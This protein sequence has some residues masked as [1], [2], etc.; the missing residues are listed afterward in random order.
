MERTLPP[1]AAR[2][3]YDLIGRAYDLAGAFE[4]R[5]QRLG[6]QQL[7]LAPGLRTL[8]IGVGTGR[9]HRHL[10]HAVEPGGLA[11]GVDLSF[12]MA[13]LTRRRTGSPVCQASA[14]RLP[15][16]DQSFDR[17][18]A[19]Y[20]LDLM[21]SADLPQA[22]DEFRR[23]LRPGGRLV[24]VA[25]TEGVDFPSRTF[26]GLWKAVFAISPTLCAGCRPLQL[27]HL[28]GQAGFEPVDTQVVVDWSVPSEIL[29]AVRP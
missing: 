13:R 28:A 7:G 12:V 14:V 29:T 17:V 25:M 9:Q 26:V 8:E 19:A 16:G 22:L 10:A 18:Y 11:A 15:F 23:C 6:T 1:S 3:L 20:I 4:S 27:A 21:S 5:G 2:R 24:V